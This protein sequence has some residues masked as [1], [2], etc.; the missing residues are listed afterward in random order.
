M[1]TLIS[2][3][4]D[5]AVTLFGSVLSAFFCDALHTKKTSGYSGAV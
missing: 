4:N 3:L 1:N 5:G 2:L